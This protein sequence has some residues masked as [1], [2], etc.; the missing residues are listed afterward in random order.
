M[1]ADKSKILF[2]FLHDCLLDGNR[3]IVDFSIEKRWF[4]QVKKRWMDSQT[5]LS[6]RYLTRQ[7]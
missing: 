4:Y 3:L 5:G 1:A 7:R 2:N 6:D